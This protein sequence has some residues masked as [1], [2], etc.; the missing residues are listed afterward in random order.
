[1]TTIPAALAPAHPYLRAAGVIA[2]AT[3]GL[4]AHAL[5]HPCARAAIDRRTGR[6]VPR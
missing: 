4:I 1:M 5:G 6:V 3:A 2:R